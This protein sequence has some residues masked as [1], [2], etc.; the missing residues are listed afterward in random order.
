MKVPIQEMITVFPKLHKHY[1]RVPRE[2][3]HE[4]PLNPSLQINVHKSWS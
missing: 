2:K 1:V 4:M 3:R